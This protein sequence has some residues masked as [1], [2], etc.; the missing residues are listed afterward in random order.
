MNLTIEL[1]EYEAAALAAKHQRATRAGFDEDEAALA[2]RLLLAFLA[3][4][5][6]DCGGPREASLEASLVSPTGEWI[7]AFQMNARVLR[8]ASCP[9]A[10]GKNRFWME[11]LQTGAV[12][13][14]TERLVGSKP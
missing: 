4:P 8:C 10:L 14:Y 7:S 13:M 3:S 6:P 11:D 5:C 9:S 1:D 12:L 2:K